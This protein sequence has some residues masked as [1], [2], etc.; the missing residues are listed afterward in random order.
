MIPVRSVGVQGDS[1]S[2]APVLAI[3]AFPSAA[4]NLQEKATELV[5]RLKGVNRVIAAAAVREPLGLQ[6]VFAS[7][8]S[9]DRLNLLR[10]ADAIVRELCARLRF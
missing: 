3:D 8:L 1:R 9:E 6:S 10:R 7:S 4:A 2:Y 5:N